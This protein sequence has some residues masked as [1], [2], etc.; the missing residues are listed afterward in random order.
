MAT[1]TG[2]IVNLPILFGK[3][4]RSY[5]SGLCVPAPMMLSGKRS[6]SFLSGLCVPSVPIL[7]GIRNQH[8]LR[9]YNA[10]DNNAYVFTR[11]PKEHVLNKFR[12]LG[13][14]VKY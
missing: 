14:N 8:V 1:Y 4:S 9:G 6:R 5:L 12:K 7:R 2:F 11:I 10:L 3:R 13:G